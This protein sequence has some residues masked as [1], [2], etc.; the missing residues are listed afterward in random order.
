M[1]EARTLSVATHH[2]EEFPFQF[3]SD[4]IVFH[5]RFS[6]PI[7]IMPFWIAIEEQSVHFMF[8]RSPQQLEVNIETK[9]TDK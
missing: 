9:T 8:R 6:P 2:M 5:L 4:V 7:R 3:A 1:A